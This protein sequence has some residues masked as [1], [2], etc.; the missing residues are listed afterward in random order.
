MLNLQELFLL[1]GLKCLK[2]KSLSK[3]TMVT[4]PLASNLS[5]V[6]CVVYSRH[7]YSLED[8]LPASILC[9]PPPMLH[10]LH[11]KP[12]FSHCSKSWESLFKEQ[13]YTISLIEMVCCRRIIQL[14]KTTMI[15]AFYYHNLKSQKV[16]KARV[17]SCR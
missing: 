10:V 11:P 12:S 15:L 4:D 17:K 1:C 3:L 9:P 2:K 8:E 14:S 7:G 13:S 6:L 16:Q 5:Y